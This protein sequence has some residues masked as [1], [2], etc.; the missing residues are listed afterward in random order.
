MVVDS[1]TTILA[2]GKLEAMTDGHAK[3]SMID[4]DVVP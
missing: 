1:R 3:E 4:Y 2:G